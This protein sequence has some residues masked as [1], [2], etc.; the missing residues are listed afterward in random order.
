MP[1]ATLHNVMLIARREYL[2]AVRTK[3]FI[4]MTVLMPVMMFGFSVVPSLLMTVDSGKKNK[5]AIAAEK[6]EYGDAIKARILGGNVA[7]ADNDDIDASKK[8]KNNPLA[9]AKYDVT[10][11][12]DMSEANKQKLLAQLD[13]KE[14]D[15]LLW[16]DEKAVE[17]HHGEYFA[18]ETNNFILL[19]N[20]QSNVRDALTRKT[21]ISKGL[22]EQDIEAAL[23]RFDM[24]TVQWEKGQAKKSNQGAKFMSALFLTLIMYITVMMYGIGVMRSVLE[25][26]KT[27]IVEVL[28]SAINPTEL[29]A[30]KI[31][32]VGSVGMTQVAVWSLMGAVAGTG[33]AFRV[34][35]AL[36]DLNLSGWTVFYF[37]LFYLLGYMLYSALGATL[38]AMCNTDQEAAQMQWL[39]ML[40]LMVSIMMMVLA[41]TQPDHPIVAVMSMVPFCAPVLMYTR[42]VV[43]NPPMPQVLLSV[44]LMVASILA[45]LWIGSR[46]YR[47]GIL[48]YGKKPTLPELMK[49]IKYS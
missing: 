8:S 33:L 49:W 18:R 36:K 22:H 23:K 32:G 30:G 44:G 31:L 5:V 26:K 42:M 47:I 37:F 1:K 15:G 16:L 19:N 40:P 41:I 35:V 2:E 10:I 45:I 24:Q 11:T 13:S 38:G 48:M 12:S 34:G 6:Q 3:L 46:V 28:M 21:L 4:I 9:A 27:R 43:S 14:L 7:E 39:I 20:I 29:L 17:E 25:E